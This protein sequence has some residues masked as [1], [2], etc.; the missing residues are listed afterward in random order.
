MPF[1]S[2]DDY[3]VIANAN[4]DQIM[5]QAKSGNQ[6]LVP[7]LLPMDVPQLLIQPLNTRHHTGL[8]VVRGIHS[9]FKTFCE[10]TQPPLCSTP[11]FTSRRLKLSARPRSNTSRR[12]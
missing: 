6:W 9:F 10:V 4:I 8:M 7:P 1:R 2:D 5:F 12:E 11:A 3:R